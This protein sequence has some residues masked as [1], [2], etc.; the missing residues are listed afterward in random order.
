[1]RLPSPYRVIASVVH[2]V[3]DEYR[4]LEPQPAKQARQ[5]MSCT[6][7]HIQAHTAGMPSPAGTRSTGAPFAFGFGKQI[8]GDEND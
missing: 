3:V 7:A 1:M 4:K 8:T 6:S 5:E 2:S